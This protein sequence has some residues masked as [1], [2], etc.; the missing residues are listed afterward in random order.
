MQDGYSEHVVVA[1]A[2]KKNEA[3]LYSRWARLVALKAHLYDGRT[4]ATV[5][6]R[7]VKSSLG[8]Q[9][10]SLIDCMHYP[11]SHDPYPSHRGHPAIVSHL[12]SPVQRQCA[13]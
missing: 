3:A 12:R 1:P 5:R 10:L 9:C 13:Q 2:I 6:A 8:E 11:N 7:L 4:P